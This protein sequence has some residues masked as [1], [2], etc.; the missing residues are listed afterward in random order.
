MRRPIPT[1]P[2]GIP[3]GSVRA[4]LA[5][6]LVTA[7][8]CLALTGRLDGNQGFLALVVSA[9]SFYFAGRQSAANL[10]TPTGIVITSAKEP[11]N[12]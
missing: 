11:Q 9:V 10:P 5:I 4:I 8:I 3:R 1:E 7:A 2:L 6:L 12:G